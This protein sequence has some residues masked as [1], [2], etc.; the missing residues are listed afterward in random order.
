[1]A[2]SI[3]ELV[4]ATIDGEVQGD[5]LDRVC[6]RLCSEPGL[7]ASWSRMVLMR[8]CLQSNVAHRSSL[9]LHERVALALA[10]E[11]PLA[12][13]NH[14]TAPQSASLAWARR[15]LKPVAGLAVAASVA[16][17]AILGL[18]GESLGPT[19][20]PS[21]VV[22]ERAVLVEAPT[23]AMQVEFADARIRTPLVQPVG[24]NNR[25][26]LNE[27]LLRHSDDAGFAGRAGFV[28]YVSIV[29]TDPTEKD[30]I[31]AST[32]KSKAPE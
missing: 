29:T 13:F 27:Y 25:A 20:E 2:T 14:G 15:Y 31:Q 28:P 10:G 26:W 11:P 18:R 16:T 9:D 3:K 24:A 32:P 5:E 7:T 19:L 30:W 21:P 4:S 22:A 1:M 23:P 8:E 17:V 12:A 6:K